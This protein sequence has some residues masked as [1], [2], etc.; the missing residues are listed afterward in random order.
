MDYIGS[1]DG[2]MSRSDLVLLWVDDSTGQANVLDYHGAQHSLNKDPLL[3]DTQNYYVLN[4]FQNATHTNVKFK[5]KI[6]TCD[7]YDI[8]FSTDTVKIL[9]SFGE[10]D[11]NYESLTWH[12]KNRGVKSVHLLSPMFT[13]NSR[14]PQTR[15]KKISETRN[16]DITVNNVTI[17]PTMNTLYWCK[18]VRIPELSNKQHIIGYEA[19]LS[20]SGHLNINIVHQM[21][22]F[23]CQTK[24]YPG[25]DPLSWDLWV[26]GSGTVCNSNLLTP[27]DWDSCSTPVAVWSPGS[28]G[29]FLPS[30][31]GIPMGGVSGVKYYMLEVH[32]DNSNRKKIVDHSGFRIHYTHDLRTYD[33]GI[34]VSGVSISD[35][36]LIPPGQN[37]YR[38][39]GICGPPCSSVMFPEKGIKII[40]GSFHSHEAGRKMSLRHIR[41]GK[42]LKRIIE[43]DNYDY[44]YQHVHQLAN[45]TVVLPG[46]YL[47]TD[48][49]Y[50]TKHRKLPTFGGY[51][52]KEEMCLTFIT[53]Y[54]KIELSGCY[55]MTPVREFFEMFGVYQFYSMNMTDVENLFLYN[56]NDYIK[57]S[58][59]TE[60]QKRS[61]NSSKDEN[62]YYD[63]N[64]LNKLLISDPVEF[65]DRTFLSH[66]YQL[67]WHEPLFTKR[68][69]LEFITGK[70]MTFCRVSNDS[71]SIPSEIIRF[72]EFT[73]Y[74]KPAKTCL[75]YMLSGNGDFR[76]KGSRHVDA[77]ILSLFSLIVFI[78]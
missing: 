40:S 13:Q 73:A 14:D 65:H 71:I 44:S 59:F 67:P 10:M 12:G 9:W 33:A 43:D 18:I 28:K 8:P 68:V 75:N 30:H 48:C 16:W 53:Y 6:E 63:D 77:F 22:L 15:K 11:P 35:T 76:S 4:G 72:P 7:P 20:H 64:L 60:E 29:Q 41:S 34:I 1:N 69:E 78:F 27:R 24:S 62:I 70:H 57:N 52:T 74:V 17:E 54:P 66:L 39:V 19:L 21:T 56:G 51:S 32:Y 26:R 38:N 42:E 61:G 2:L 25:S 31:V 37:I 3:D 46:D 55:S 45:E 5:R 58:I 49:A 23:E 47:I 50:E 36:Q